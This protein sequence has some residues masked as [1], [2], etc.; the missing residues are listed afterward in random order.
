MSR[1]VT[2]LVVLFAVWLLWSGYFDNALLVALGGISCALVGLI[3]LRMKLVD[4]EGVPIHLALRILL[5]A[6]W[7]VWEVVKANVDVAWRILHPRLP[8]RPSV[9]RVKAGQKLDLGRV[10]YANSITL[11]PGTVSVDLEEDE[12]TVHALT[13][14]AAD[15]LRTGNMDRK[16]TWLEGRS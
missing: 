1:L 4:P 13:K 5:Y 10:I 14:E 9:I 3:A 12:I 16:V 6:P 2:L 7:L 11:T 8:I 15:G